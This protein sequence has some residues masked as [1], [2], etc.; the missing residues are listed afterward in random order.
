[1]QRKHFEIVCDA[2]KLKV[3]I[4]ATCMKYKTIKKWA[5]ILHDKDDTR[6]HYHIYVNFGASSVPHETVASWF[7]VPPN[8]VEKIKGR[9][10]DMLIY[11]THGQPDQKFKYQYDPQEVVSNFDF[12]QEIE[13][14]QVLGNFEKYSYAEQIIYIKGL[15]VS[16]QSTAHSK[17]QKLW[18]LHCEFSC[19]HNDRNIEVVFITGEAG[20][21]KT[22]YAKRMLEKL[23]YDY[24]ISSSSNDPFQDYLGQKAIILDDLRDDAF[25]LT[26]LLKILDNN[27][28]SSVRSRFTNKVFNGKMIVIT[29]LIPLERWYKSARV[30]PIDVSYDKLDQLYRRIT[31]YVIVKEHVVE[32]Y[33]HVN[34]QGKPVKLINQVPNNL[35]RKV[36]NKIVKTDLA[37]LF[38]DLAYD[39]E[40]EQSDEATQDEIP[41]ITSKKKDEEEQ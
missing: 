16:E 25:S 35:V 19:L 3:D 41:G 34:K 21:G 10:I 18:K 29:C 23:N 17:L 9:A 39:V 14:E 13:K 20:A 40:E 11:L 38:D 7:E 5:Y 22:L 24:C 37:D 6:A 28:R 30:R 15:P 33:D 31:N 1:M 2:D 32:I 4:Q 36:K 8:L 27:T 26:D 12:Q